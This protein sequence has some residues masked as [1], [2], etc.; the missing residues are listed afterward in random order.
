MFGLMMTAGVALLSMYFFWRFHAAFR[1]LG[2]WNFPVLGVLAVPAT[3]RYWGRALSRAG[4]EQLGDIS[5]LVLVVWMVLLF[6]F[7]CVG[8]ALN[9]WNASTWLAGRR[10]IGARR[11]RVPPRAG[12]LAAGVLVILAGVWG[13]FEA[14]NVRVGHVVV[15]VDHL[16]EGR[17]SLRIAQITDV[18]VGSFYSRQRLGAAVRLL[19]QLEPDLIVSTGDLVDDDL[20]RIGHMAKEL[21]QLSAPLGKY[22]VFGNHE[23]YTGVQD[24]MRFH[25]IS[26]FTVLR[27][28]A[29]VPIRG[30]RIVGV[31]D[32]A[33][34]RRGGKGGRI[35]EM[36]ILPEPTAGELVV[37]LKHQ[38]AVNPEAIGRFD[39]QLSGHTH[40][41]QVFPF[42]W[43]TLLLYDYSSGRHDLPGGS[44]FYVSRGTG[45]WGPPLRLGAPPEVTLVE[46]RRRTR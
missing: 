32:P 3:A 45:T 4:W 33:A 27:Q 22:A 18:H 29:A 40:G 1:P 41:G 14:R 38:P 20:E 10:W 19:R 28:E 11:L 9:L 24:S 17:D 2:R 23:F 13:W 12:F 31:D 25:E 30:L 39:L 7:L 36:P 16:P 6:W 43:L 35:D 37:L 15:E 44:T 8:L 21:G 34:R 46:L 42:E 5:R 26:G